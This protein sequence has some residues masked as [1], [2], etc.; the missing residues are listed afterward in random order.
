MIAHKVRSLPHNSQRSLAGWIWAENHLWRKPSAWKLPYNGVALPA[1][2]LYGAASPVI[3][4]FGDK[5]TLLDNGE[6]IWSV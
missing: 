6:I 2:D 5:N 1:V 4:D 3:P